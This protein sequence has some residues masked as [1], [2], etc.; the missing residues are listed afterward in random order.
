MKRQL[1]FLIS[2]FCLILYSCDDS[3]ND[4][5]K[6]SQS[7]FNNISCDGTTLEVDVISS[8]DWTVSKTAKW[9]NV[10]PAKGSG[11][12]K[13]TLEI[14][15]N[16]EETTRNATITITPSNGGISQAIKITQNGITASFNPETYHYKLPVIFHVL[17]HDKNDKN[18]YVEVGRLSEILKR[19]NDFTGMQEPTVQ[20]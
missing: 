2:T 12:Q 9:C 1:L 16:L 11:N 8:S 19:V 13:L 6:V 18:Q 3:E 5:L 14:E 7:S 20:I 17:Y 10:T 4:S 15:A